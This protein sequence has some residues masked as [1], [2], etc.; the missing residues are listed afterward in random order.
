MYLFCREKLPYFR[1]YMVI[2]EKD[3]G[4]LD[5][6]VIDQQI[7]D[8]ISTDRRIDASHLYTYIF[9]PPNRALQH[10]VHRDAILFHTMAY[11][12]N[13]L[14]VYVCTTVTRTSYAHTLHW[15]T[16]GKHSSESYLRLPTTD[17]LRTHVCMYVCVYTRVHVSFIHKACDKLI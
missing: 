17:S 6:V 8:N 5:S 2:D 16:T 12:A 15:H 14:H 3:T 10:P 7:F 4:G 9:S 11:R 1:H 13:R